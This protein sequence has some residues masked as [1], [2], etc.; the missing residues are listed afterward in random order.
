M[1][2][3]REC[4]TF[5]GFLNSATANLPFGYQRRMACGE[6]KHDELTLHR[7]QRGS[8][9]GSRV[10]NIATRLG[11]TAAIVLAWLWN[12]AA[13]TNRND[14]GGRIPT[15]PPTQLHP[16]GERH[17][18]APKRRYHTSLA[19]GPWEGF[20]G[21]AASAPK[22]QH[23]TSPGQG[24]PDR[25]AGG[26]AALGEAQQANIPPPMRSE[27]MGG[28]KGGGF[29]SAHERSTRIRPARADAQNLPFQH[30]IR[31]NRKCA[32]QH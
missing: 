2:S 19:A 7:L 26:A 21:R 24:P 14:P 17:C 31:Q 10:I 29:P 32:C 9:C 8:H 4:E 23:H 22:R 5:I 18:S 25:S 27:R 1:F 12:R 20:H 15:L 6:R 11:K 3:F 30:W 13:L 16:R 28:G